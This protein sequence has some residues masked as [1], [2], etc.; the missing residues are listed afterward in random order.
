M[1][2]KFLL[3]WA[4]L[5]LLLLISMP[6]FAGDLFYAKNEASIAMA[7]G[8]ETSAGKALVT[9]R[10]FGQTLIVN[11]S[12]AGDYVLVYDNTSATGTPKLDIPVGTANQP[13]IV[14]LQE[15]EFGTGVY[16][17]GKTGTSN[18]PYYVTFVYTQ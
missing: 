1:K 5:M 9:G 16:V 6:C 4:V 12:T 7:D 14:P 15:A 3:I 10:C 17:K 13:V 18:D 2:R 8:A 11:A